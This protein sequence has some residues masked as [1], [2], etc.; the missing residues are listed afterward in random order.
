MIHDYRAEMTETTAGVLRAQALAVIVG[1]EPDLST[2]L[3]S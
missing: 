3:D 1:S 2:D